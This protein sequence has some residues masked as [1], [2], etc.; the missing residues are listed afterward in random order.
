MSTKKFSPNWK[1]VVG[2]IVLIF[3]GISL[4][5][6]FQN[7]NQ[8][9]LYKKE[10][11][12]AQRDLIIGL[13]TVINEFEGYIDRE[14]EYLEL[15]KV[16][17]QD[18]TLDSIAELDAFDSLVNNGLYN[19]G[20]ISA[21]FPA[22]E[23]L[24]NSGKINLIN[25]ES[26]KLKLAHLETGFHSMVKSINEQLEVQIANIDP[27]ILSNFDFPRLFEAYNQLGTTHIPQ[28]RD[29]LKILKSS[30]VQ[31]V[32]VYKMAIA[33]GVRKEISELKI[34][35]EDVLSEFKKITSND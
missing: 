29:H 16:L 9:R 14:D 22:Y 17:S 33:T 24:K 3:I 28:N 15:M 19:F 21:Q 20:N 25:N 35:C 4:A 10:Q 2:E 8:K 34:E 26:L 11:A 5:I 7:W 13:E 1:Y 18:H 32:I 30:E 31:N 6:S 12:I 23:S 27:M